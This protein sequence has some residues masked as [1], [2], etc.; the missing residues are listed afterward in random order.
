[1]SSKVILILLDGLR[2]DVAR[3]YMGYLGHLLEVQHASFHKIRAEL[4]SLSRPLYEVLLTGTPVSLN[5]IGA[6]DVVR[7]S[8]QHSIFHLAIA[9]GLTTAAA[10]Y[11]WFSE[12]YNHAPFDLFTEREQHNP[13]LPIQHGLFYWD[14]AYPD[15]HLFADAER[16]IQRW[17]PDFM[18][19]HPMGIDHAGHCYGSN[20]AEYRGQALAMDSML[21]K[22]LPR[23]IERGYSILITA[24][25]G[26][27][28]DGN[29]GGSLPDVRETP[30]FCLGDEFAP[31][32]YVEEKGLSQLAIAP[33]ICQML[34]IPLADAMQS[35]PVPGYQPHV[36]LLH[37]KPNAP[38]RIAESVSG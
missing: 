36:S 33:L 21:A 32:I 25:H 4:P 8:H 31:G 30:L 35:I 23:W 7:L 22:F 11:S 37:D 26:M 5:G 24:D 13:N 2:F 19:V 34:N 1:M 10:A 20:T 12:L 3:D 38:F 6:N 15:S 14:D 29:H 27:N 16:L 18:L 28:A 9:Q 17:L